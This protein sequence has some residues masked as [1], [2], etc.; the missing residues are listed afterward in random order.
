MELQHGSHQKRSTSPLGRDTKRRGFSSS[1]GHNVNGKELFVSNLPFDLSRQELKDLV[2]DVVGETP[3]VKVYSNEQ[4][5]PRGCGTIGFQNKESVKIALEK[6]QSYEIK[7]RKLKVNE[8][9]DEPRDEFGYLIN[10]KG[11]RKK[12]LEGRDERN[13]IKSRNLSSFP[14]ESMSGA[15]FGLDPQFLTSIGI[16]GD[17]TKRIW[18]SNLDEER[19]DERKLMEVFRLAGRVAMVDLSRTREGKSKGHAIIEYNHPVEAV[20]AI[21]MLNNSL[22]YGKKVYVRVDRVGDKPRIGF[23]RIPDGLTNLGMGLGKNGTP[24]QNISERFSNVGTNNVKGNFE[25]HENNNSIELAEELK[26]VKR[27][28]ALLKE[29][30]KAVDVIKGYK[31]QSNE[32]SSTSRSNILGSEQ[33]RNDDGKQVQTEQQKFLALMEAATRGFQRPKPA[34]RDYEHKSASALD[35]RL[36]MDQYTSYGSKWC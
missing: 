21:S 22:I 23:N 2:K 19:V 3:Y 27:D 15:D 6:M 11:L 16:N 4:G 10:S 17:L 12:D 5:K 18:V 32:M 1:D 24:L 14:D 7:G 9:F 35:Q 13:I 34:S 30:L 33:S 36:P 25:G 8:A 31:T 26:N 29:Q 28:F 20:Q